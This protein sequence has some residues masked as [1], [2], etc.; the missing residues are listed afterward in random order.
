MCLSLNYETINQNGYDTK[1]IVFTVLTILLVV[2]IV[3]WELDHET[4]REKGCVPIMDKFTIPT[5]WKCPSN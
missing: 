2:G 4:F 3:M 5:K 1:V